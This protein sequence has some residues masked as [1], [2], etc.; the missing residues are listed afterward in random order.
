[1][2]PGQS[3]HLFMSSMGSYT[4]LYSQ[5]IPLF[6]SVGQKPFHPLPINGTYRYSLIKKTL[7]PLWLAA[8]QVALATLDSHNFAATRDM[9]AALC[10]LVGFNFRHFKT[11]LL[12]HLF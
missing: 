4:P 1:M 10:P 5:N 3:Q 9:E 8:A 12:P 7:G 11:L 6:Y 2:P